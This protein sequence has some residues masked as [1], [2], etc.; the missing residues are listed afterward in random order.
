M[1]PDRTSAQTPAP[2]PAPAPVTPGA[3]PFPPE[4]QDGVA[5]APPL[6]PA[7]EVG[8]S[9][10]AARL[11]RG[12]SLE[13]VSQHTRIPRKFLEALEAGRFD[14]L[15]APVYLRSFLADYCEYLEFEF[16]PLWDKLHPAPTANAAPAPS[17]KGLPDDVGHGG[18]AGLDAATAAPAQGHP[19]QAPAALDLRAAPYIGALFSALGGVGL[20]LAFAA[21]LIWWSARGRPA[22]G[23]PSEESLRPQALLPLRQVITP[24]LVLLCRDETWVSVQADGVVLFA[25]RLPKNARQE[26]QAQKLI[27]LRA[28]VPEH[29]ALTLNGAPYRL[30]RPDG[31]GEY[32]IVSP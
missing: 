2:T 12:Y 21:A 7:Q 27:V 1:D 13:S 28:P 15:P 19:A 18:P 32:R 29:L 25:G 31:T 10:S 16:R 26:F 22:G 24:K 6:A 3:P 17:T 14:D 20:S 30:P 8:A 23:P 11:S 5:S 9:L 4:G